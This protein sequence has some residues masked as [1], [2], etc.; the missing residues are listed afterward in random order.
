[1]ECKKPYHENKL[2]SRVI[3]R[4]ERNNRESLVSGRK[5]ADR[6]NNGWYTRR[7]EK[8]VYVIPILRKYLG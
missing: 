8:L 7:E 5:T 1:M 4:S 3:L 2:S 6:R